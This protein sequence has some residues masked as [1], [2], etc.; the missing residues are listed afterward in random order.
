MNLKFLSGS[1]KQ[2]EWQE[3]RRKKKFQTNH[4][5][6]RTQP[7]VLSVTKCRRVLLC[8]AAFLC[9]VEDVV[10]LLACRHVSPCSQMLQ[11]L[12]SCAR[13]WAFTKASCSLCSVCI[14]H[15]LWV[16]ICGAR[17]G[18]AQVSAKAGAQRKQ[19]ERDVAQV[20]ECSSAC[21]LLSFALSSAVNGTPGW[22]VCQQCRPKISTHTPI[23]LTKVSGGK[24]RSPETWSTLTY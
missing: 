1:N 16:R 23:S 2:K 9:I 24:T 8:G 7:S 22:L 13:V 18:S 4:I 14:M 3:G 5:N 12:C 19:G 15:G 6:V 20:R 10:N 17:A 21:G 11:H